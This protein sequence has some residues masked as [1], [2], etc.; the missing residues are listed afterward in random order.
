MLDQLKKIAA[1]FSELSISDRCT[2]VTLF[3]AD[4][5][6][7]FRKLGSPV[8]CRAYRGSGEPYT[9]EASY[10]SIDD[11]HFGAQFSRAATS[12]EIAALADVAPAAPGGES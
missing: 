5:V 10:L 12:E 3:G 4:A 9:I 11:C 8:S 1:A 7:E 6:A 2:H